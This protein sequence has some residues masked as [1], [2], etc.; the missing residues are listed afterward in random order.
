MKPPSPFRARRGFT[1]IELLVVIAIIAILVALLLPAVQSAREAARRSSCQNHLKQIGLALHG[2]MTAHSHLPSQR[3]NAEAPVPADQKSFY[4]WS[5]LSLLTP[6]LEQSNVYNALDLRKPLYVFDTGP[7]PS[8]TTHPDLSDVVATTVPT[9]LCPSDVH[10]RIDDDWGSTNYVACQGSG[11]D[12]GVYT[13]SDGVFYIDSRT[14]PRDVRDGLSNTVFYSEH[15]IGSG[16]PDG[17]RGAAN[18]AGE[19]DVASVWN[20]TATT[21]EDSWCLDDSSTVVFGRGEKW[22]DGSVNDTGYHHFRTPNSPINDCYS[23]LAAIKSARS[24]HPGGVNALLG[25]GG[26]R[27]FPDDVEIGVWR[28]LAT[29]NGKEILGDF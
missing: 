25:D 16:A 27:F 23:R 22:A 17:T 2:Y 21:V 8:V 6:F 18:T 10:V 29:R 11:V 28:G 13:D 5:A 19:G 20:A 4:R 26:V 3:D 7:P 14:T 1:L 15:L 24:R 9:F 12:G